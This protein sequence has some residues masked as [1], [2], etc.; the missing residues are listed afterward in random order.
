AIKYGSA[1]SIELEQDA[2]QLWIRVED[3]G[4]GIAPGDLER[5]FEPFFRLES[6]RNKSTGG[7]GLGLS[8]ARAIV[9]E[10]GGA[11][12]LSNRAGGGLIALVALPLQGDV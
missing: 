4:P 11:L 10:Q 12:T 2:E 5:V 1:P 6:S 7:V 9:L 3:H 8:A